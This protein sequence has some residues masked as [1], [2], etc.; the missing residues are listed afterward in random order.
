MKYLKLFLLLN[1]VLFSTIKAQN[2]IYNDADSLVFE[3]YIAQFAQDKGK[4]FSET[5]I[6]T[7]KFFLGRPYVASTLETS[8]NETFIINLRE[9][10]CTTFVENCIALTQTIQSGNPSFG[11][12]CNIL[13]GMRYRNAII[14]GYTSRL[15]YTSDWI[16]E[17]EKSGLLNNISED[18]GGKKVYHP[19][20][21]MSG[22]P[23][24]YKHLKDNLENIK[25]IK[26]VEALINKR[27]NY[28]IIP[29]N[30]LPENIKNIRSGDL[31]VFATSIS[32][33]DYSH[34]GIAYWQNGELHFIHASSLQK[35]VVIEKKTLLE[36]C[37]GSKNCTGISILRINKYE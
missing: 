24:S 19:V 34:I 14:D 6:N 4:P 36:Y 27:D 17:N 9:L 32:G 28:R 25:K 22:H 16:Y 13:T 35:Q 31:V 33:L 1:C 37:Q 3:K 29:I 8:E 18:I 5:L 26:E 2:V 20:S 7:A 12:Y 30:V 10:D 23:Q 15:H 11:N 21:F